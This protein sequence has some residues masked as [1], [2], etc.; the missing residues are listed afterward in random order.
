M[1]TLPPPAAEAAEPP[2][3]PDP[4]GYDPVRFPG[5]PPGAEWPPPS[6][7]FA[8]PWLR[9]R[10]LRFERDASGTVEMV[11]DLGHHRSLLEI[12]H[13]H[14]L[15]DIPPGSRDF[16]LLRLVPPALRLTER[17]A[18][19]DPVPEVLRGEEPPLPE[20]HHLYAATAA[21]V[22]ELG[23]VSGQEGMALC[24]ALRRV[25]PGPDMIAKAVARCVAHDGF[26]LG[27]IGPLARR[28][29]RLA[30]AH[31]RVLAV[32][33][34]QPDYAGMEAA[35]QRMREAVTTDRRWSGDLL[36]L[37]LA[38]L[39]PG[40]AR[41]R[42]AAACFVR[43]A[44]E[45]LEGRSLLHDLSRIIARQ[46]ELR[47]RLCDLATFWQRTVLAWM[48]VDPASTDRRD[49]EALA[50]NAARRLALAALYRAGG[51]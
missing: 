17:V 13:A 35:V 51:T 36:A 24:N 28:L 34:A 19:G 49:V 4:R 2:P 9:E 23:R 50:R 3:L 29:Q 8:S 15:L 39:Q 38:A 11:R 30:N 45:A 33:A 6:F 7:D 20:T 37:A 40:I 12:E 44:R 43:E 25:P 48:A 10:G 18:P 41:P 26:T 22:D 5:L 14:T 1:Q 27:A 42:L 46:E 16:L 47:D 21:L 31:A 32:H